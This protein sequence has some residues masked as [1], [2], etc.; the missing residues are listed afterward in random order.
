LSLRKI[1]QDAIGK[2]GERAKIPTKIDVAGGFAPTFPAFPAGCCTPPICYTA[3]GWFV[4]L[5][6]RGVLFFVARGFSRALP[7]WWTTTLV[8]SVAVRICDWPRA[9]CFVE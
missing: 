4:D 6:R 7:S 5:I 2:A 1:S 3:F 8:P 9:L